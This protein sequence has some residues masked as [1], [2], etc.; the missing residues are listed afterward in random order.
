MK[1]YVIIGVITLS[2]TIFIS[3]LWTQNLFGGDFQI[4][5]SL[6]RERMF[7]GAIYI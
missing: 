3:H 2:T 1:K 5:V 6:Y 4:G 7:Y